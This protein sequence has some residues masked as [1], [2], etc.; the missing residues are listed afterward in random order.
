[1]SRLSFALTSKS[2]LYSVN[3]LLGSIICWYSLS[4]LGM[5]DPIWSIITVILVSDPDLSTAITLARM[6]VINTIVGCAVG[7]ITLL[8]F[9]YNPLV[10]FFAASLIVFVITC[11]EGY[12]A[13]W[14]LTPVTVIIVM[15][16][17]RDAVT[18]H[19]EIYYAVARAGEIVAGCLVSLSIAIT[20]VKAVTL[21]RHK[22][23][24]HYAGE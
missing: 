3:I 17:S 7:L 16:A 14:R 1:M 8:I 15:A 9:G 13:N 22:H 18:Y 20:Q 11:I 6:R 4:W 21:V 12:P 23:M 24:K 10:S 19:D 2:V 5:Q